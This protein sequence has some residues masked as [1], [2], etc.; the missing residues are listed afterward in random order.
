MCFFLNPSTSQ[1]YLHHVA[2]KEILSA[3][4]WY[5][6]RPAS[7]KKGGA[8]ILLPATYLFRKAEAKPHFV[9]V[10]PTTFVGVRGYLMVNPVSEL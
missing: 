3:G 4:S 6:T 7:A 5:E 1:A 8:R 9:T 10:V 2:D